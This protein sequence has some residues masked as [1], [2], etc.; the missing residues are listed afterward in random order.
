VGDKPW[1]GWYWLLDSQVSIAVFVTGLCAIAVFIDDPR[2]GSR[3][4]TWTTIAYVV[5]ATGVAVFQ[6]ANL[7]LRRRLFVPGVYFRII[8]AFYV[9]VMLIVAFF[10]K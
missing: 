1:I 7:R 5:W 3:A 9:A 6:I 8:W 10:F 2:L 4:L